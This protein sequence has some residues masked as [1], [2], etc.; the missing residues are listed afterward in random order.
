VLLDVTIVDQVITVDLQTTYDPNPTLPVLVPF[1]LDVG[2]GP[3]PEGLYDLIYRVAIENPIATMPT[4]PII[5]H[6]SRLR[7]APPGD[8]NCDGVLN[9]IDVVLLIQPIFRSIV[10]P[11]EWAWRRADI[12]CDDVLNVLD[13]IASAYHIFYDRPICDPCDGVAS[14]P[15]VQFMFQ[16]YAVIQE[17][18]FV[19]QSASI[20]GDVMTLD[21]EYSG[22]CLEH[23]FNLFSIPSFSDVF[24]IHTNVYLQHIDPGD[25]CDAVV[26]TTLQY[27]LRPIADLYYVYYGQ[28][29]PV[30]IHLADYEGLSQVV[31]LYVPQ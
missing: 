10:P 14:I 19:I 28:Y 26:T 1:S 16:P 12:N 23:E 7:V 31:L 18:P 3:L 11:D 4:I 13:V 29:D 27:D 15:L 2:V 22:G 30:E 20:D 5:M 6:E 21:V 9:I 25:P 24:P 17:D 8:Q